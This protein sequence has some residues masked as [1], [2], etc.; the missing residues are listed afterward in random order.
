ML[1]NLLL[2]FVSSVPQIQNHCIYT[3]YIDRLQSSTLEE[4]VELLEIQVVVIQDEVSDLELDVNFLFDEQIIQ[5]ER[6]LN[7]DGNSNILNEEVE[8]EV[9]TIGKCNQAVFGKSMRED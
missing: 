3:E 9:K 7:L 1:F 4:R 5:D 8:G 6:L 2:N